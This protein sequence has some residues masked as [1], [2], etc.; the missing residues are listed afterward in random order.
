[1][2][3]RRGFRRVGFIIWIVYAIA[4]LLLPYL[5][6]L[7]KERQVIESDYAVFRTCPADKVQTC[8]VELQRSLDQDYRLYNPFSDYRNAGWNLLWVIPVVLLIPPLI[9]LW[10]GYGI[11]K[12]GR[13]IADGFEDRPTRI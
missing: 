7:H 4:V 3:Y 6:A 12:V 1:M 13:W 5:F 10:S 8:E 9:V 2:N 11:F